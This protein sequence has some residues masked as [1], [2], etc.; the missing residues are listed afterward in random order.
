MT[1]EKTDP[2]LDPGNP[3]ISD[4]PGLAAVLKWLDER[5]A[6]RLTSLAAGANTSMIGYPGWAGG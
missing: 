4:S 2:A 1:Q 6:Y 3:G 5:E